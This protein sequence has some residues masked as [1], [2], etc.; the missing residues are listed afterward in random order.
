MS[1]YTVAIDLG[2]S[3]IVVAVGEKGADGKLN[4]V[5]VAV[6]QL[7]DGVVRGEISN[8]EKTTKTLREMLNETERRTG[9]TIEEATA[10]ISGQ[11]IQSATSS[12]F[13]YVGSD[14]EVREEDVRK[15]K[16][17]MDN[18]QP[19]SESMVILERIPQ[20]Y[21]IDSHEQTTSPIGRFGR[22]LGATFN[23][24]VANKGAI[25]R[26]QKVFDRVAVRRSR[27]IAAPLAS[28]IAVATEDEK[29]LGVAV[30]DLGAGTT[31]VCI[32]QDNVLRHV[33]V[34]PMGV[35][36]INKDIRSASIPDLHIE[37]LKVS[38]GYAV[39]S[40]IPDNLINKSIN[41]P[42]RTKHEVKQ[43]TFRDLSTIIE[44]RMLDIIEYVI[45]EIKDSGMADRL[46]SGIVLTGGGSLMAGIDILFKERTGYEVRLASADF[47]ISD[48]SK[49]LVADP[50]VATAAGLLLLTLNEG[51]LS[52]QSRTTS[53]DE[54]IF[55]RQPNTPTS[56]TEQN[57]PNFED[58]ED[59]E[60]DFVE[61]DRKKNKKRKKEKKP[62][63][64]TRNEGSGTSL[65][66][67]VSNAFTK[68]FSVVDDED[69]SFS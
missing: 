5:D 55:T 12:Y 13:V 60:D 36:A 16:E 49:E 40:A 17:N 26:N 28:A 35:G 54:T 25:E 62:R 44:A 67:K 38:H 43:I 1:K 31:N 37:E 51:L 48:E 22:Q 11:H 3:D 6:K 53:A 18:V 20:T 15:L 50:R 42:G 9:I 57:N 24:I 59:E 34:I 52:A 23:F 45:G 32:M 56:N 58:D 69:E 47:N 64:K 4:I 39:A 46:A 21:T 66:D 19:P 41:I 68:W 61:E 10:S 8:I 63:T 33:A 27:L 14:G 30:I 29:E 65:K 7:T 2:C